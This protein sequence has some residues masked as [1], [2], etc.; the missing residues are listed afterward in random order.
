MRRS[1]GSF[2]EKWKS[3]KGFAK[4]QYI[5]DYFK[6]SIFLIGVGIYVV[7][8]LIIRNLNAEN[9][10]L[11]L[12]YV[13]VEVG[14]TLDHRL[15]EDFISYLQPAEK[16][17]V[18]KVLQNLVLTENLQQFDS[19]YIHASQMKIISSIDGHQLDI[20]LMNREAFDAFSQNGYLLNVETFAREYGLT[21]LDPFFVEN[22]EIL[23]DNAEEVML[24]PSVEY[25]SETTT[26]PMGIDV[27]G[28]SF[29]Q[30][31]GFPDTVYL[32]IIANTERPG[33]A[34]AFVS[35]LAEQNTPAIKAYDSK[36]ESYAFL[37]TD[38]EGI[39]KP[40]Q[41]PD[42]GGCRSSACHSGS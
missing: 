3:L 29:F 39:R 13:N 33:N 31:A 42:P 17:S 24:D 34:A 32:G 27:S 41:A 26:Y 9:P 36:H 7:F 37:V 15:T 10:Q 28:F 18:V 40:P 21:D 19:S 5:W 4:I 25:H 35:Y 12:A 16:R 23:S 14:E 6:L 2:Q 30:E 1:D 11:Y 8:Y 22:L 20:V 38:H